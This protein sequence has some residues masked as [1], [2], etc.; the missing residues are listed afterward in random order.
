[1]AGPL[2]CHELQ[3]DFLLWLLEG[4]VDKIADRRLDHDVPKCIAARMRSIQSE[5]H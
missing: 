5:F 2:N 1:M 4:T 3:H